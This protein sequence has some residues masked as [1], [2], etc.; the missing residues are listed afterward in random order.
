MAVG[1]DMAV[2]PRLALG[3]PGC[4]LWFV[5][6]CIMIQRGFDALLHGI[7]LDFVDPWNLEFDPKHLVV[8][9][10]PWLGYCHGCFQSLSSQF[11]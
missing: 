7:T 8:W 11:S 1:A 5:F 2:Q 3:W 10:L 4:P 6:C 9:L